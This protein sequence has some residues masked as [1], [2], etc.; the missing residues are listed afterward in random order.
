MIPGGDGHSFVGDVYILQDGEIVG[1][2]EAIKFLQWPRIMLNRFFTQPEPSAAR[3]TLPV[4]R[5]NGVSRLPAAPVHTEKVATSSPRTISHNSVGNNPDLSNG[6]PSSGS[7][8]SSGLSPAT[9]DPEPEEAREGKEDITVRALNLVAQE[10]A[11]DIGMLTDVAEIADFG[12]DSLMSLVLAA[13]LREELGIEI[14]DA[15]FLEV[16]TVGDLKK[17][18][19]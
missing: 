8:S 5:A 16:S 13:R 18:L 12:L 2:V 9:P 19:R 3:P 11:V 17:L 6:S 4:P 14:R 7:S 15:F 10:L 1:L